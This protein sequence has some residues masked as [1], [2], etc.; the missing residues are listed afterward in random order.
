MTGNARPLT[1]EP[2]NMNVDNLLG[3][4]RILLSTPEPGTPEGLRGSLRVPTNHTESTLTAPPTCPK[5]GVHL[6][7]H[8]LRHTF[9]TPML[10][11]GVPLNDVQ[12]LL[13]HKDPR[14]TQR[15]DH[16]RPE[17]HRRAIEEL[18]T[19]FDGRAFWG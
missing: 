18:M 19:E 16:P 4:Q 2:E 1:D 10:D 5:N 9:A 3:A 12:Y 7:P 13:G 6:S 14:M 8:Q 15:Y 17:R 11:H